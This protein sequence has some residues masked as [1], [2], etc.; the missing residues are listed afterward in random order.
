MFLQYASRL[1]SEIRVFSNI[2]FSDY[3]SNTLHLSLS[4]FDSFSLSWERY[5]CFTV[6][7]KIS[8]VLNK[9]GTILF[10]TAFELNKIGSFFMLFIF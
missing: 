2:V 4:C 3:L 8:I 5:V 1:V 7:S 6:F 9:K 10:S